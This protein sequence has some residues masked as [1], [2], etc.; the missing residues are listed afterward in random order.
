[1]PDSGVSYC[2]VNVTALVVPPAKLTFS[3][4]CKCCKVLGLAEEKAHPERVLGQ[5]TDRKRSLQG[6]SAGLASVKER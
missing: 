4:K 6:G 3:G 1:M 2:T 5:V